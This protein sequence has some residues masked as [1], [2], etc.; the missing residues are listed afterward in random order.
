M[1]KSS[2]KI[3]ICLSAFFFIAAILT[4]A[5]HYEPYAFRLNSC[6]IC[7]IKDSTSLSVHKGKNNSLPTTF[8][9][10]RPWL[11]EV[12]PKLYETLLIAE[13]VRSL[14]LLSDS[15]PN[16]APPIFS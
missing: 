3:L 14:S 15:L 8:I 9:V 13:P 1:N 12:L 2:S 4:F 7:S 6:S 11:I 16:K 10:C 5:F